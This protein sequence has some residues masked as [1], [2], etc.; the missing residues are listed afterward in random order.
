MNDTD[1]ETIELTQENV[2]NM[3]YEIRGQRVMLDFD[4][5]RIYG[6]ST[7]NFNRQVKNNIERFGDD[8]MFQLTKNEW[9][10]KL[11]CKNFT[12]NYLSKHRYLPYA[13]TEQGIYMLMTVLKGEL[14]IKQ[15]IALIRLFKKMKDFIVENKSLLL[16]DGLL[17]LSK[18]VHINKEEI[19]KLE[20]NDKKIKDQ[21]QVVLDNFIDPKTYKQFLLLDGQKIEADVAY[22]QLYSLAEHSILI[23]DDYINIK[24]LEHLK[25]CSPNIVIIIASDNIAKDRITEH[26]LRDFKADTGNRL[27]VVPTN[28]RIHDRYIFIDYQNRKETFY[29]SGSSSKDA[30]NKI[31]TIIKLE[32]NYQYYGLIESLIKDIC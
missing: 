8:F 19:R 18:Q 29:L 28:S 2:G 22:R 16:I 20:E 17:S 27:V 11:G 1:L 30:G 26:D 9:N 24:T 21:L 10:G 23:V 4:L 13:F 6:Y 32:D 12:A 31:T 5:A 25:V 3:I 15:S 14:A 7:K